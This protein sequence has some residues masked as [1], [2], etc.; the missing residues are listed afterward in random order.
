[1]NI[2]EAQAILQNLTSAKITQTEI[3]H[4]LQKTRSDISAKAKRNTELRLSEIQQIEE[5]FSDKYSL[6]ISLINNRATNINLQQ[7]KLM[8]SADF[9]IFIEKI[10]ERVIEKKITTEFIKGLIKEN[11]SFL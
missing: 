11:D 3:G 4:A 7:K 10:C 1:M 9:N 5:Y 8:E 6:N 2:N